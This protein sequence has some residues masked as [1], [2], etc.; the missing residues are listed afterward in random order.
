MFKFYEIKKLFFK[1]ITLIIFFAILITFVTSVINYNIKYSELNEEIK[2]NIQFDLNEVKSS[3]KNYLGNIENTINSILINDIFINY[4]IENSSDNKKRVSDLFKSLILSHKNIF[5]LRFIDTKG[6]EKIKIQKERNSQTIYEVDA[7]SLQNKSDRYYFKETIST[8]NG[9]YFHSQL[10][11]NIENKKIERPLRPTIR[12]SINIFH[13]DIFY[14]IIIANVDMDKLLTHIKNSN[15]FDVYMIDKLGNFII[16]PKNRKAWNKYLNNGNTVFTEFNLPLNYL[17]EKNIGEDR[18]IFSLE[19]YFNNKEELKL[20]LEVQNKYLDDIKNSNLKYIVILGISILFISILLG[21]ILSIPMSKI[22]INFNRLYKENLRFMNII[23][24]H[25]ITMTVGLDRKILD[26]SDA[27]CN[28]SRYSKE[29]LLG[30]SIS[31]FNSD[32]TSPTLYKEILE[33]IINGN[34]WEG[35]LKEKTKDNT[36]YW[37]KTTILPNF[38]DNHKIISFTSISEDITDKKTIEVL[39]QTDKLTQLVNRHKMDECLENE[40]DRF[41]R[42]K[43]PFSILLIDVD[44][45]KEVNDNFGHQVG[46]TILIELSKIFKENSRKIDIVG[47]W[48]G[49]EFLIICTNTDKDGAVV[50][51]EKI[52][53]KVEEF[54]FSHIQKKTIS[55]G[56]SEIL[57]ND[58]LP[59]LVKRADDNLYLAKDEG[60]NKTIS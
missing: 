2:K 44:K 7:D 49:E 42:V 16:H 36:Y 21:L 35:E 28:V 10:D 60:R 54:T 56:V 1:N 41:K 40:F 33:Q 13:Q 50:Y 38:D 46:D 27:L 22:Y 17:E 32:K 26:V 58:T 14:G 6:F 43:I 24:S 29:E 3:T 30:S 25:I 8:K 52:R 39:S 4:L 19:N 9:N 57:E 5:Q 59:L 48:G 34:I 53:K 18:Y 51:A 37:L 11:L 55:I 45:F 15:N 12:I 23:N 47:R 20:I 31:I